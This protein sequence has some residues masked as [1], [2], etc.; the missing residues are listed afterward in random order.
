MA[1]PVFDKHAY[2]QNHLV[3]ALGYVIFFLPLIVNHKSRYC[4]F[5]AN[6][7]AL[8]WIVYAAV[9]LIFGVLN[10]ILG[11]IPLIGWLVHLAGSL[12]KLAVFALMLYYGWNA[13]NGK[14]EALPYI[15]GIELFR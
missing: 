9:A 10:F 5:C 12:I 15:G 11:W 13:Y 8:A 3:G 2:E 14:A 1:K 7:G 6:Q 4:R